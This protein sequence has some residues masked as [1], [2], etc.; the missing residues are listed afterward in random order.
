MGWGDDPGATVLSD[1]VTSWV[2]PADAAPDHPP[3]LTPLQAGEQLNANNASC[4]MDPAE[5]YKWDTHGHLVLRGVMD[6]AWIAL[7]LEAVSRR[8]GALFV[9]RSR[10]SQKI[11]IVLCILVPKHV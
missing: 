6:E 4:L 10:D 5:V 7:A 2:G 11:D 8:R 3:V 9:D 1:G